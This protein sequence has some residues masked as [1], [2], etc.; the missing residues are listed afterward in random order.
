MIGIDTNVLVRYLTQDEPKQA[1]KANRLIDH[2]LSPNE[3]GFITLISLVEVA[4]LL[5]SCYAQPK[6]KIVEVLHALLTTRQLLVENADMAYLAMKRYVTG[7]ADFSD[8]LIAV[9]SEHR[10]C[11]SIVTFDK[12]GKSIG[13]TVL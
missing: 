7:S 1:A 10:G 9:I 12:K 4:W 3:P 13:M 2:E 5:E 8:A 11:G 6:D